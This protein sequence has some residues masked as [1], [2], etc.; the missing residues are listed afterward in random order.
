MLSSSKSSSLLSTDVGN[1]LTL[2]VGMSTP[3]GTGSV[4]QAML[5]KKLKR[6]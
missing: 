5:A 4:E 2:K 3:K 6:M 1:D